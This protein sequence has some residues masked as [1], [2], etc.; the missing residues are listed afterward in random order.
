MA[1]GKLQFIRFKAIVLKN[2]G[3]YITCPI[4]GNSITNIQCATPDGL[5]KRMQ[6]EKY[7]NKKKTCG[8][9]HE[10]LS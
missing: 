8:E 1:M 10:I 5:Y 9:C 2:I 3:I 7:R 4:N 6:L